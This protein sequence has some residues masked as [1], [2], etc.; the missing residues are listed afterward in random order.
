MSAKK[1]FLVMAAMPAYVK[2]NRSSILFNVFV[3]KISKRSTEF[4]VQLNKSFNVLD[5]PVSAAQ[6]LSKTKMLDAR[7]V[8]GLH[9]KVY[10]VPLATLKIQLGESKHLPQ[11]ISRRE[12][13]FCKV[14][15]SRPSLKAL[16]PCQS[17]CQ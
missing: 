10:V 8:L 4:C 11:R 14:T 2:V 13:F 17:P 7:N 6:D 5:M 9:P 16:L 3:N 12:N 15:I 1:N